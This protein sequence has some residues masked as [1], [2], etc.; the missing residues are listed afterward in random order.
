MANFG[1]QAYKSVIFLNFI[2]LFL[3]ETFT[4]VK[5]KGGLHQVFSSTLPAL[6]FPRM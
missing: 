1:K 5:E 3:N 6:R 2:I 4:S